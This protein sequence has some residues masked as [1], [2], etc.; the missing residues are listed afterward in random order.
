MGLTIK[1]QSNSRGQYVIPAGRWQPIRPPVTGR[2]FSQ[3]NQSDRK[4]RGDAKVPSIPRADVAGDIHEGIE[5]LL[6]FCSWHASPDKE[7]EDPP[8]GL[9]GPSLPPILK[10]LPRLFDWHFPPRQ[11]A[12]GCRLIVG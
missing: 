11:P 1:P 2:T 12:R 9:P 3:A 10:F 6:I 8:L 7:R 4:R 5:V